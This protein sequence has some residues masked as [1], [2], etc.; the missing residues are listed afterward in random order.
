MLRRI[1]K[2]FVFTSYYHK[3][4]LRC[5]GL[6]SFIKSK[7]DFI[8]DN[9][10]IIDKHKKDIQQICCANIKTTKEILVF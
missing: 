3:E 4:A 7:V 2:K 10:F 5:S 8:I 6:K 9:F 1:C